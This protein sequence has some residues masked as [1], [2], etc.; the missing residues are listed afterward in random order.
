MNRLTEKDLAARW[1]I[2]VDTMRR[3][4]RNGNVP[5]Y[6]Q[7]GGPGTVILYKL[8]DVEAWERKATK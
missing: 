7:P 2:K 3:R 5:R 1:G 8:R 6:L 4:R